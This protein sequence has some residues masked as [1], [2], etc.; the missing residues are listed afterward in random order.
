MVG[1]S[2]LLRRGNS[3][4]GMHATKIVVHVMQSNHTRLI[5]YLFTVSVYESGKAAILH[6][7]R[8]ILP[9]HDRC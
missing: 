1:Q 9:L 2:N 5:V 3:Q 7:E 6:S 4:A 8:Q